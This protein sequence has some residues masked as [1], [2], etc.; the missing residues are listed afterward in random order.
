MS[1]VTRVH[2]NSR[3]GFHQEVLTS[4]FWHHA[5]RHS[6]FVFGKKCYSQLI[7]IETL[8]LY[9]NLEEYIYMNIILGMVESIKK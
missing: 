7:A 2:P 5:F 6:T 1:T 9:V 3:S 4:G 8:F